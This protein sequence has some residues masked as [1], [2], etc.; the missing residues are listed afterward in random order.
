[1]KSRAVSSFSSLLQLISVLYLYRPVRGGSVVSLGPSKCVSAVLLTWPI[2][3][4]TKSCSVNILTVIA[5]NLT[6]MAV[7]EHVYV[8]VS[9]WSFLLVVRYI[10][11]IFFFFYKLILFF[12]LSS[13]SS[14]VKYD[15][16]YS[17]ETPF[18]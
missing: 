13:V 2:R 1:M 4:Y 14:E 11:M 18:Y 15:R 10:F 6:T 9:R 17:F 3:I 16:K 7:S 8:H 5:R 12:F